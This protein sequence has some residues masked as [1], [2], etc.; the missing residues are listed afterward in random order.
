MT[1]AEQKVRAEMVAPPKLPLFVR[2]MIPVTGGKKADTNAETT[3]K[4]WASH[5]FGMH[6][7]V[8]SAAGAEQ[9]SDHCARASYTSSASSAVVLLKMLSGS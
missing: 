9:N 5:F 3:Q 8:D 2:W 7:T 1:R 6:P 4:L